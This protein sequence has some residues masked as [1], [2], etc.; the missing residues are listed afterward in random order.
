M[1]PPI[2]P[3]SPPPLNSASQPPSPLHHSLK[4]SGTPSDRFIR[5]RAFTLLEVMVAFSIFAVAFVSVA[6]LF[7]TAMTLQRQTLNEI[8]GNAVENNALAL[9]KARPFKINDA[10]V[11]DLD[12]NSVVL[13]SNTNVQ[14]INFGAAANPMD[15]QWQWTLSDR[16][17]PTSMQHGDTATDPSE[18][19]YVWV[20]LAQRTAIGG[21]GPVTLAGSWKIF[22]FILKRELTD[23]NAYHDQTGAGSL[24][25]AIP[26]ASLDQRFPG[27]LKR[28][29]QSQTTDR[30]TF[31]GSS[32]NILNGV[33]CI[34]SGD[35]FLDNNGNIYWV[36]SADS[37]GDYITVD[38]A[39][40][41]AKTVSYIWCSPR[42]RS[43]LSSPTVKIPVLTKAVYQ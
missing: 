15:V 36:K 22:V 32:K 16:T 37:N 26:T 28:E 10:S 38:G 7:P 19:R 20:P 29:V 14:A 34:N 42:P 21:T 43:N 1:T 39:L 35:M 23:S 11:Y 17:F 12:D 5:H 3:I 18:R 24:T 30:I 27:V 40:D 6:V 2:P 33:L 25:W 9:L 8:Q 13:D 4:N 41:P 31:Q